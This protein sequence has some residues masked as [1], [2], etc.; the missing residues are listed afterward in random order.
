M[1]PRSAFIATPFDP[2]RHPNSMGFA[3]LELFNE[4][5]E[6]TS[7]AIT[8]VG[9]EQLVSNSKVSASAVLFKENP[10]LSLPAV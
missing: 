10:Y 6:T 5:H 1:G 2:S 8:L 7:P 9:D 4:V 3:T